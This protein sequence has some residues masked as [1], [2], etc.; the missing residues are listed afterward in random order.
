MN[1]KKRK[2]KQLEKKSHVQQIVA[3]QNIDDQKDFHHLIETFGLTARG[4]ME[5]VDIDFK[6]HEDSV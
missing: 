3:L 1:K 4:Q 6:N 5:S 2:I